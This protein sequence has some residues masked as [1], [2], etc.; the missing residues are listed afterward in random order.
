MTFSSDAWSQSFAEIGD[1]GFLA[2]ILGTAYDSTRFKNYARDLKSDKGW[3]EDAANEMIWQAA[4]KMTAQGVVAGLPG[5]LLEFATGAADIASL[6]YHTVEMC[7]VL[8]E[9]YGLD[10]SKDRVKALV[11]AGAS[12]NMGVMDQVQN[13]MF[14]GNV[15]NDLITSTLLKSVVVPVLKALGVKVGVR[16]GIKTASL[17]PIVGAFVDGGTNCWMVNDTGHKFLKKLKKIQNK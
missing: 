11:L 10:T 17:I 3:D 13:A 12:G 14:A 6:L 16:G 2:K 15:A 5:G 4:S 1:G 9:I 8:A 7:G